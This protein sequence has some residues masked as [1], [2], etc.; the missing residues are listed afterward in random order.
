M[1]FDG[2]YIPVDEDDDFY[3]A[4]GVTQTQTTSQNQAPLTFEDK[5]NSVKYY[6][7]WLEICGESDQIQSH[8]VEAIDGI[9]GIT[10]GQKLY[11][12]NECKCCEDHVIN[13]PCCFA[14]WTEA[15]PGDQA[16][17]N[18]TCSCRHFARQICRQ[19]I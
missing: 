11:G 15:P 12:L 9:P 2:E 10:F 14:P 8:L 3:Q 4:T 16:E 1:F 7:N 5:G 19:A 18:C 13:K 17:K 6:Q